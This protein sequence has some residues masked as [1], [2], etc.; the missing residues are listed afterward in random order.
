MVDFKGAELGSAPQLTANLRASYEWLLGNA[1]Y[2][3]L[4]GDVSY[5]DDYHAGLQ[6]VN[7]VDPR[8]D[9]K[10]YTLANARVAYGAQD[11]RWDIV[12][13]VHNIAD[14]YYYHSVSFSNDAITRGVGH[15]RTYGVEF[16]YW[17]D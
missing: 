15:G 2:L 16:S 8:F 10:S 12:A 4:S 1:H 13:R 6:F 5:K 14:E 9:V 7:P 11:G 17:W 3:R